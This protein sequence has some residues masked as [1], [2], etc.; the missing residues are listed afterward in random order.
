MGRV[1]RIGPPGALHKKSKRG[2]RHAPLSQG[3]SAIED[4][5]GG[6]SKAAPRQGVL[7]N[8][9]PPGPSVRAALLTQEG[10]TLPLFS[11]S[12][13]KPPLSQEGAIRAFVFVQRG[14]R[15]R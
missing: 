14:V 8:L 12:C 15:A 4:R 2:K 7:G 1:V 5:A 10:V 11:T 13:A 3:G 6:G 9:P